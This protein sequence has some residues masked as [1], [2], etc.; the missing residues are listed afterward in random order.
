MHLWRRLFLQLQLLHVDMSA[1]LH[2][3]QRMDL[4]D[5]HRVHVIVDWKTLA[6]SQQR[7][8]N[9]LYPKILFFQIEDFFEGIHV[10]IDLLCRRWAA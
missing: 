4:I 1:R 5:V 9:V 6:V 3:R 7:S 8:E 2:V 10:S